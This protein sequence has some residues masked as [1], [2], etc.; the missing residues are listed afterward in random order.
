MNS[1]DEVFDSLFTLLLLSRDYLGGLFRCLSGPIVGYAPGVGTN[2]LLD[3]F[4]ILLRPPKTWRLFLHI[5]P[6]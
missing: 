6:K 5:F 2:Y 1:M 4:A 3:P